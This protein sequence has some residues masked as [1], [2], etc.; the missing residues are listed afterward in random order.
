MESVKTVWATK[1]CISGYGSGSGDGYGSGSVY[2]DGD[3]YGSGYGY[4]DGSGDGSGYGSG[5][6]Y[7][8]GSVYGDGDGYGSG[9]GYGDGSGY[10]SGSGD[11]SGYGSGSGDGSGDG[12]GYGSG[13]GSG[14]GYG[15]GGKIAIETINGSRVY[16]VDDLATVIDHI[17]GNCASGR[18]LN[19]DLTF[20][21]CYICKTDDNRYYAH[22]KTLHEARKALQDKVMQN[23]S[24][25]NRIASFKAA[26]PDVTIKIPANELN[27]WH[28]IL[29]GSCSFGREQFCKSENIDL[30]QDSFSTIEFVNLTGNNYNGHIIKKLLE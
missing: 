15:S 18:L 28:Y 4:G 2:G 30:D 16:H 20:E 29:T 6:G 22:G 5:D 11:G 23:M 21:K 7:G 19:K 12:S 9:Y 3:G 17:H 8:S 14:Y 1:K 10:G 25:E 13:D 24:I 27:D 26:Y